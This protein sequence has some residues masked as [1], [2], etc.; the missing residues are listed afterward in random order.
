MIV[1]SKEKTTYSIEEDDE[2]EQK[3]EESN[4]ESEGGNEM[5]SESECEQ[6]EDKTFRNVKKKKNHTHR[7]WNWI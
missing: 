3:N 1:V 5:D 7:T 2:N 4:V 6:N